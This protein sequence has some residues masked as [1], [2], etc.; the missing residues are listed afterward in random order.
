MVRLV[1]ESPAFYQISNYYHFALQVKLNTDESAGTATTYGI[2]S[3]PT[4]LLFKDGVRKD[5]VVG[6]VPKNALKT[7]IDRFVD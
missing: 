2:R 4:V 6:A 5:T 1:L 3:I 7:K